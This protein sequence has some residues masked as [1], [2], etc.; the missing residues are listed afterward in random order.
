MSELRSQLIRLAHAKPELRKDLLPLL[1]NERH[2][3]TTP[4]AAKK[5]V[6]TFLRDRGVDFEKVTAKT[7]GFEDLGRGSRIF[8]KAFVLDT[9]NPKNTEDLENIGRKNGFSV[10]FAFGAS[11]R[12]TTEPSPKNE[13]T[14]TLTREGYKLLAKL[15]DGFE[16]PG[17]WGHVVSYAIAGKPMEAKH[18]KKVLA[19]IDRDLDNWAFVSKHHEWTAKDKKNLTQAKG[20]L[21]NNMSK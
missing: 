16:E 9:M 2:A 19:D 14:V 8:V 13:D 15:L 20:L 4:Q 5:L 1:E 18:V 11:R 12:A 17:P 10:E 21:E 3:A 7:I 6:E